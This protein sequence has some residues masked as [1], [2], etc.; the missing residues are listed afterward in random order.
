M[1]NNNPDAA[2]LRQQFADTFRAIFRIPPSYAF[3][4]FAILIA[5]AS[6]LCFISFDKWPDR[7]TSASFYVSLFGFSYVL[8]ELLRA[9][10]LAEVAR[11]HY[12]RAADLMRTQHYQFC[13][14]EAQITLN[15]AL[16]ELQSRHWTHASKSLT[17]LARHLTNIHCLRVHA[18]Q[19]WRDL[20]ASSAYWAVEFSK[21]TNGR[22]FTY[23][24][25]KWLDASHAYSHELM[26]EST[27]RNPLRGDSDDT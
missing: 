2:G 15:T 7:Y 9:K 4:F 10:R 27:N 25:R 22:Q 24:E 17:A 12:N 6:V 21:G 5:L 11:E 23:D 14:N 26:A 13:L 1:S 18:N 20:S 19:R 8:F 3:C 16:T